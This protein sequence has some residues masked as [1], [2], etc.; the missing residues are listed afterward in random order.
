MA[1]H[2][3]VPA[4]ENKDLLQWISPVV[5]AGLALVVITLMSGHSITFLGADGYVEANRALL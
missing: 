5:A 3:K 2:V 1:L 4:A